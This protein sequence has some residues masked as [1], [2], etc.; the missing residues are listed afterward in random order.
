MEY[1]PSIAPARFTDIWRDKLKS[2]RWLARL[3]PVE[4]VSP[5][6]PDCPFEYDEGYV[7]NGDAG[8]AGE[9]GEAEA[10]EAGEAGS[11][12]G[13]GN[14]DVLGPPSDNASLQGQTHDLTLP[15][16]LSFIQEY[17]NPLLRYP[18]SRCS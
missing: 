4:P 8:E 1:E 12:E 10:G 17:G 9:Q 3:Q 7:L 5:E 6:E 11:R 16:M 18:V 14:T 13:Y 2:Q 15:L